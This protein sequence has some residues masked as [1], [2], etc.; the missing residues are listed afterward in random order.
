MAL[1]KSHGIVI[2]GVGDNGSR[3][4]DL[5]RGA[6]PA[7]G[8]GEKVGTK[9]FALDRR[10]EGEPAE[11]QQRNLLRHPAPQLGARQCL[12]LFHRG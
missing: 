11:Q 10:I 1:I 4:G 2:D 7:N 3:A 6:A 8:I 9:A 12:P 5:G